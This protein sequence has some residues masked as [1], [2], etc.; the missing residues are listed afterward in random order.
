MAMLARDR[1]DALGPFAVML[2]PLLASR[3]FGSCAARSSGP[4]RHGTV[5]IITDWEL[6]ISKMPASKST[7]EHIV[8]I[9][10]KYVDHKTALKMARDIVNHVRGN[11]SVTVTFHRIVEELIEHDHD[12]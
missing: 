5:T 9:M 4:A 2:A 10:L 12:Q 8:K 3:T 7:V 1:P 11:Q 6:N